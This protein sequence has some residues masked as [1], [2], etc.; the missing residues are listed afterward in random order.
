M[1]V[2]Q[3]IDSKYYPSFTFFCIQYMDNNAE[4]INANIDLPFKTKIVDTH[5]LWDGNSFVTP[6]ATSYSIGGGMY[7]NPGASAMYLYIDGV[8]IKRINDAIAGGAA[9]YYC[10][11]FIEKGKV[12]SLRNGGN[13]TLIKNNPP[14]HNINIT[15][16]TIEVAG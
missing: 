11:H 16:Y 9:T 14:F 10:Q 13:G 2:N 12:V 8:L 4:A 6:F 7:I 1:A 15:A 3:Y 5:N